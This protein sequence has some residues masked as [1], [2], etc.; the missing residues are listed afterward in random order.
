MGRSQFVRLK[1]MKFKL[2]FLLAASAYA[3][4]CCEFV[5]VSAYGNAPKLADGHYRKVF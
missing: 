5:A 2:P 1:K 3:K 4:E